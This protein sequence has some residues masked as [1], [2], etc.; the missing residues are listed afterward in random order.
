MTSFF[1][2]KFIGQ[3]DPSLSS[4]LFVATSPY[5]VNS[6]LLPHIRRLAEHFNVFVCTNVNAY[7][8]S[9]DVNKYAEVIHV[10]MCRKPNLLLDFLTLC[11]LTLLMVQLKPSVVHSITPKGGILATLAGLVARVPLRWHTFTG[12]VWATQSGFKRFVIKRF[13]TIISLLATQVFVDSSSQRDFLSREG[14]VFTPI[15]LLGHGSIAG[16][17]TKR[18]FPSLDVRAAVRR[19]YECSHADVIFLFVGRMCEEKG[20]VDLLEA[21]NEF[22]KSNDNCLLWL[23]G[24]DEDGF[25]S[26][27]IESSTPDFSRVRWFGPTKSPELFMQA[28]DI[29]VLPSYR[30]GFGSVIIEAAACGMPTIAYRID[31]VVDAVEESKSGI[32]VPCHS[33]QDL[34][35]A[36]VELFENVEHRKDM[37]DYARKR[38]CEV[39][40]E[41]FVTSAWVA[42]YLQEVAHA[43]R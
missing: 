19:K 34:Y 8:M 41:D 21:F 37:G 12:Q 14:A 3:R 28:A 40:S 29:F 18:F 35:A 10:N 26:H 30:E 6:F 27:I 5:A 20:V 43:G 25:L 13:D 31:G 9:E 22:S 42:H 24:P 7:E 11:T 33:K 2:H 32:L 36:M 17:D 4:V 39:F 38:A 15:H 16:V 23:V 1:R